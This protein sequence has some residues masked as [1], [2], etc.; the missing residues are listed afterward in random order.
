[1]LKLMS[2]LNSKHNFRNEQGV[3]LLL[4]I[5]ILSSVMAISFSLATIMFI[6][7]RTSGD[8][9]KTEG[10]LYAAGGVGEEAFFNI[11]RETCPQSG[12]GCP[13]TTNFSNNVKL[14][15]NPV[16][17]STSTPIIQDK[18]VV[19]SP[20]GS[21]SQ[22]TYDFCNISTQVGSGCGYGKVEIT[23]LDTGSNNPIMVY[24][25][26]FDPDA[27]YQGEVPCSN[28][29]T[30]LGYWQNPGGTQLTENSNFLSLNLNTARQQVLIITNPSTSGDNVYFQIKTYDTD[31]VTPKG[32][33]YVG[34]SAV[35]INAINS[36]VGRKIRVIV[37]N[38]SSSGSASAAVGG[39]QIFSSPTG[40]TP[41]TVP[42]YGTLTVK[43]W[44]AGGGGGADN[45]ATPGGG[46]SGGQSNF[47]G[48]V[49]ALGGG[50]GG[51]EGTAGG[52][53]GSASGGDTNS[54]G[55]AGETAFFAVSTF[56]SGAG[57]NA[58][59]IGGGAGGARKETVG[60]GFPGGTPGGGGGG[61]LAAAGQRH[62]SGGGGGG[63]SEK[64]YLPGQLVVGGNVNVVV[65]TGGNGYSSATGGGRGADG[66]VEITWTAP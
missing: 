10:A 43:V 46:S 53:G 15:G 47:N 21:S 55:F 38:N 65:G 25:C 18:V 34:K 33:P 39:S 1:M 52:T 8:L 13:Y 29:D 64:I 62:G 66:R 4:A 6:E 45:G 3:T 12:E 50:G 24:L 58:A 41:F 22:K 42:S 5:I 27:D 63:Y 48:S 61:G 11:K 32:L 35:D 2:L 31:M 16:T 37:P 20:F 19:N 44:G 36:S 57:G 51:N 59:G 30:S 56:Y 40:G 26:E 28:L 60:V 9:L 54:T 14:L 7:V 17:S 49:I 23:Y